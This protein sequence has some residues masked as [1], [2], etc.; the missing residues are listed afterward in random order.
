M[1]SRRTF[2]ASAL[3]SIAGLFA[4]RFTTGSVEDV[5]IAMLRKRLDYLKLDEDGLKAFARDAVKHDI[6]TPSKR[7]LLAVSGPLYLQFAAPGDGYVGRAVRHGEERIISA[8][9]LSTDF[10]TGGADTSR[11]V[12]YLG[13]Y[14][15]LNHPCG[16]PF[17]R[18]GLPVPVDSGGT[19]PPHR[20]AS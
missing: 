15:P 16:N 18:I 13:Y 19:P 9:L 3:A 7:H 8:Y 10:F 14:D 11:V 6:V 2:I 1:L 4:W 5:I 12:R 20:L 17:A